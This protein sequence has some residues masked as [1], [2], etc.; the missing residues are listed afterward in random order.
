M[1]KKQTPAE[2]EAAKIDLVTVEWRKLKLT[3]PVAI[4]DWPADVVYA[5]YDDRVLDAVRFLLGPE[6]M[7]AVMSTQPKPT[8]GVIRRELFDNIAEAMGFTSAG[9]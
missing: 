7:A 6:Q 5:V 2:I 8:V 4:E 1:A 3:F 9:E